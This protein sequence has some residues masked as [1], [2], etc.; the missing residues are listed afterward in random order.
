MEMQPQTGMV[1]PFTVSARIVVEWFKQRVQA[2]SGAAALAHGPAIEK[3]IWR[4]LSYFGLC[5]QV[6]APLR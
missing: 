4:W 6:F 2:P 3:K 5:L 1:F